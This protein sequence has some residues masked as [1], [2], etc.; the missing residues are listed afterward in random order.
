MIKQLQR[1]FIRIAVVSLTVAMV[2]VVGIVNI[3]NLISVRKELSDTL[4]L[5]SQANPAPGGADGSQEEIRPEQQEEPG[6]NTPDSVQT[7][8][9]E[10]EGTDDPKVRTQGPRFWPAGNPSRHFR[11]MMAE[12]NWFSGIVSGT[13]EIRRVRMDRMETLDESTARELLTRAAED[14]RS[15]GFI[16][17]YMFSSRTLRSGNREIILMNCET[18]L[19]T[20]RKLML[21]SAVA[22][23]GGILLA[24]LLVTLAS[25]KAVE[26]TIRNMEQ[27]KQ[28]ITNA[29]HELKTPLTI[30]STNMELLEM[31]NEGNPWILSTQKQ[32]AALRRL[33]D[34]LVYLSRMEE[35]RPLTMEPLDAGKL[36]EETA[37]P[38][39]AM[40][41]FNGKEMK[42][43]AEE[44]LKMNGDRASIQRLM[45]T[46]C[47]NAVKYA[48]EGP[49]LAEIREEGRNVL[50]TVSNPVAEP[51][52]RQQCEQLF[53]RFYRADPSR[54]KGKKGGFG[55][56][57]A[58]AAAIAEK[59]GG[60]IAAAMEAN[61][62][63]FRCVLP[64]EPRP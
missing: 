31:E 16:Q 64:K 59:H 53:N 3:A 57:L 17:D 20:L 24:W 36:L 46:L 61:R 43:S 54:N 50:L 14:G 40:A 8:R 35:G 18:R 21:I 22:C 44:G 11:N 37:E 13:G 39:A 12:T 56:G 30:I 2:L 48:S 45:S 19:A 58:I 63:V 27:Q 10:D 49:I 15:E 6:Q 52:T 41:E 51:L 33:V 26:P 34:E 9:P 42:V 1:R 55:I 28:F 5:L 47:D 60:R 4:S 38:F 23:A 25:R 29:S 32:T 7:A 62:L